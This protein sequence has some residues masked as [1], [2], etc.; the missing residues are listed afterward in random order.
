MQI[1]TLY[2]VRH[3]ETD[4]NRRRI[5]QGRRID[6]S[7]NRRGRIQAEALAR[8]FDKVR[9]DA[10][11]TSALKR[12][13]ETAKPILQQCPGASVHHV[14]DLDEMCWGIH[15]GRPW[16]DQLQT[17][18]DGMYARWDRGEFD[19]RVEQG[20]SILD[21]QERAL[22]GVENIVDRH[23]GETVLVVTH[24]RF[25]RVL[26]STILDFGLERM[27]EI[28]HANTGVNVVTFCD[29]AFASTLLNCTAH[30]EVVNSVLVE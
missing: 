1:T 7:L 30:L 16:S 13:K 11:Y 24:G 5:M 20:E 22:R 27:N 12:T 6:S 9:F 19:Y 21:V 14:D 28:D 17:M 2:F 26:L 8:R 25:L 10:V 15:E 29:G 3:G 18:I 4:H 23:A